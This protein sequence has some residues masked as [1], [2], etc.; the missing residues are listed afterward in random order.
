MFFCCNNGLVNV[1]DKDHPSWSLFRRPQNRSGK[2]IEPAREVWLQDLCNGPVPKYSGSFWREDLFSPKEFEHPQLKNW[3]SSQY[4]KCTQD[5]LSRPHWG[6]AWDSRFSSTRIAYIPRPSPSR[7]S[8]P[9]W[10]R[11]IVSVD[12]ELLRRPANPFG[13][14]KQPLASATSSARGIWT[15][16]QALLLQPSLCIVFLTIATP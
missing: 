4:W 6:K 7:S 2:I 12:P 11:W 10:L 15:F 16:V 13:I 1:N 3:D 14:P 8:G 5:R 9:D